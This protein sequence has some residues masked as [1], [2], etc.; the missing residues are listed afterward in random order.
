MNVNFTH[1][2][3]RRTLVFLPRHT[4][5]HRLLRQRYLMAT[6]CVSLRYA[7]RGHNYLIQSSARWHTHPVLILQEHLVRVCCSYRCRY[8]NKFLL[9]LVRCVLEIQ[10]NTLLPPPQGSSNIPL[11]CRPQATPLI[12]PEAGGIMFRP[13]VATYLPC[14]TASPQN[15]SI[16]FTI[17]GLPL[18]LKYR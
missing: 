13:K 11:V 3:V 1:T 2:L 8:R 7:T 15:K 17:P 10:G 12:C 16:C 6:L 9:L 18:Q 5:Y 14:Y 4:D